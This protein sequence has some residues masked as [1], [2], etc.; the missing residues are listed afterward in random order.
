M[1]C[2][3][4]Q[5]YQKIR[6]AEPGSRIFGKAGV[7][8]V[9]FDRVEQNPLTTTAMEAAAFIR[10]EKCDTVIG[11]GGGSIMDCAKAAA[12]LSVNDGDINDYIFGRRK[13]SL[14]LPIILSRR[15]AGPEARVTVLRC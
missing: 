8:S 9:V 15:P 3:R 5:Q 11:L 10:Q 14:A 6:S 12:F 13:S 2:Y 4:P 1:Y 7:E